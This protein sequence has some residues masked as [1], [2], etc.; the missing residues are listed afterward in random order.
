MALV[1]KDRVKQQTTTTGTG[2]LTLSGSYPGF[3]TF[4]QIGDG[5]TTYY[6][7]TDDTT[8]DWEVGLGTYT[9]AGTTLSRDTILASSNAGS[10]VDLA[11][12]TKVV[13]CGYPAGKSVYL[14]ASGNL[15]ISG[16]VSATAFTG[17]TV[18]ATSNIHTP[19]IS[20]T[21]LQASTVTATSNIHTPA[22]SAT[23]ILASTVSATTRI[24]TPELSATSIT[25][26]TV[27]AT[28]NIH[29]PAI[30]ATSILAS[31]VSATT[32]IHTPELSATAITGAT[33]TATSNIHTPSISATTVSAT[34]VYATSF[35][36]NGTA[37]APPGRVL[38]VDNQWST[39]TPST[40]TFL[41]SDGLDWNT[42]SYFDIELSGLISS[43]SRIMCRMSQGG[44]FITASPNYH[45]AN[46]GQGF[47]PSF[48]NGTASINIPNASNQIYK[49]GAQYNE[50]FH[51]KASFYNALSD[52][53]N[54]DGP[55]VHWSLAAN[56]I[57]SG[58]RAHANGT[59]ALRNVDDTVVDGISFQTTPGNMPNGSFRVW[60]IV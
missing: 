6:V 25:G 1:V 13:F 11:A 57:G 5:N 50:M 53:T 12:G 44:T 37:L 54:I 17:A 15:G 47:S 34:N 24:H 33:V 30:S 39:G 27:T 41:A 59:G 19:T 58:N 36:Q 20:V 26:A 18:T 45:Y 48:S 38:L 43:S 40:L 32:R 9:A 31:T 23:S 4:S 52:G 2:T 28:S 10:A 29:T 46:T 42:Y 22:I 16:T 21:D 60:G 7:I 51:L 3:D 8:G 14:D 56:V 35:I 55:Y 49:G